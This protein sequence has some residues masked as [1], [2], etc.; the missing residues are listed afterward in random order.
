MPEFYCRGCRHVFRVS[1]PASGSSVVCPE[2]GA[3]Q[4]VLEDSELEFKEAR[5]KPSPLRPKVAPETRHADPSERIARPGAIGDDTVAAAHVG[6]DSANQGGVRKVHIPRS[7]AI[8]P[9]PYSGHEHPKT[10]REAVFDWIQSA[11]SESRYATRLLC[12]AAVCACFFAWYLWRVAERGKQEQALA[13]LWSA[14]DGYF[15]Q[16]QFRL[17]QQQYERFGPLYEEWGR[18]P[19]GHAALAQTM[20]EICGA[21]RAVESALNDPAADVGASLEALDETRRH[22]LAESVD[23]PGSP[24]GRADDVQG[25]GPATQNGLE[26][27]PEHRWREVLKWLAN[28]G[29][30]IASAL[31]TEAR[32]SVDELNRFDKLVEFLNH[33]GKDV[34][35]LQMAAEAARAQFDFAQGLDRFQQASSQAIANYGT[36]SIEAARGAWQDL[37]KQHPDRAKPDVWAKHT[38]ELRQAILQGLKITAP[39]SGRIPIG[40][41]DASHP[42]MLPTHEA[43]ALVSGRNLSSAQPS[44]NLVFVRLE[45]RCYALNAATGHPEWACRVGF[46]ALWPPT[47]IEGDGSNLV[48]LPWNTTDEASVTFA[49]AA[50]LAPMWT[51]R[52]PDSSPLAG[53][54]IALG[55][56][57]YVLLA[58]GELWRL[59]L[60]DGGCDAVLQFPEPIAGPMLVDPVNRLAVCTGRDLAIY[61]LNLDERLGAKTLALRPRPSAHEEHFSVWVNPFLLH[62]QNT[63]AGSC[64]VSVFRSDEKRFSEV[65]T[66]SVPGK[67]WQAPAVRGTS[68]FLMT[69][70]GFEAVY[71]FRPDSP[72]EPL[73]AAFKSEN[74]PAIDSRPY[75]I[76][77]ADAPCVTAR[78]STVNCFWIDPLKPGVRVAE[79]LWTRDLPYSGCVVC[80][81]L[82]AT[83][84]GLVIVARR[85]QVGG[86]VVECLDGRDGALK[87]M[88]RIG[89]PV[90][91][92]LATATRDRP[93]SQAVLRTQAG[94]FHELRE[95]N[96][97]WKASSLP[98][99]SVNETA[100][101]SEQ[102]S[103]L[104]WVRSSPP[105][106]TTTALTGELV[107]EVALGATAVS[108]VAVHEGPLES[109]QSDG[110]LLTLD[111]VWAAFVDA[112]K[113]VQLMSL[114][115]QKHTTHFG[116]LVPQAP[117]SGWLRPVWIDNRSL[118]LVHPAGLAAR[119]ETV[120][121]AGVI[122][123][124]VAA[125]SHLGVE[126]VDAPL[127]VGD[128]VWICARGDG[129]RILDLKTLQTVERLALSAPPTTPP[130]RGESICIGL[131]N[132][133]IV[134]FAQDL[135]PKL[136]F[137]LKICNG[138]VGFLRS[139][140]GGQHVFA[141]DRSSLFTID[142]KTRSVQSQNLAAPPALRPLVLGTSVYIADVEGGITRHLPI[143]DVQSEK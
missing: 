89:A 57:V 21:C 110:K 13:G 143:S 90:G 131:Q 3:P 46:D 47:Q 120:I 6:I 82:Q 133:N 54:P 132:G 56:S 32:P 51:L 91:E 88:R 126:I 81:D 28:R 55:N 77:H 40:A 111:G 100:A 80:Q 85:P 121:D 141:T 95:E 97:E 107:S 44:E 39:P 67:L 7:A 26:F 10:S 128:H 62:F 31:K 112:D 20:M 16:A 11:L 125:V 58:K 50:D 35:A 75:F 79:R 78:L 135:P 29:E 74:A 64:D 24:E 19:D 138:P 61:L 104:I 94:S 136:L 37:Q 109:P 99:D 118:L 113:R 27:N 123:I 42:P 34:R 59:R 38:E 87:W 66:F 45:D 106:L 12:I 101:Y 69:D 105:T 72:G 98:V 73:V 5:A 134:A 130:S 36:T 33:S 70:R 43:T 122:S 119:A 139:Q 137:E 18:K 9:G 14:A 63:I 8:P 53:R 115:Q 86:V 23:A 129:C 41:I 127:V 76:S 48:V 4:T 102:G 2:C 22:L 52:L 93:D 15:R 68:V 30:G 103:S 84:S 140:V 71:K 65:Q 83:T 108:P 114:G 142:M 116:E 117:T 60:S 92:W 17:A 25:A 124:R 49:R 96:G 1:D